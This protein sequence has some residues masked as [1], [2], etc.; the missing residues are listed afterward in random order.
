MLAA[1]VSGGIF[2][3]ASGIDRTGEWGYTGNSEIFV[4]RNKRQ[5]RSKRQ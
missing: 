1:P 2:V 3:G 4:M 5:K